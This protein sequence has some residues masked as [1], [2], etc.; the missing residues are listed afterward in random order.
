MNI[1]NISATVWKLF[2]ILKT[3]LLKKMK[4]YKQPQNGQI[5][6]DFEKK[7]SCDTMPLWLT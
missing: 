3:S 5:H 4:Q 1:L 6:I 2:W 7:D